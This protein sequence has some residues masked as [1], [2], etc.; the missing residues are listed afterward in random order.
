[1][2]EEEMVRWYHNSMDIGW[3]DSVS[4]RWTGRPGVVQYMVLQRIRHD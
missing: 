3:V 1:M 2:T 4:W